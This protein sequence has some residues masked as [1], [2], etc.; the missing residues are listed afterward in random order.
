[1]AKNK[2]DRIAELND[3]IAQ[4][5]KRQTV[6]R[7]QHNKQE[8]KARN[9]RLCQRGGQVEKLLP[10]L[11]TLTDE[12]FN[13]FVEK[14]LLTPFSK[15]VLAELTSPPKPA[16]PEQG[17]GAGATHGGGNATAIPTESA[18]KPAAA[19]PPKTNVTVLDAAANASGEAGDTARRAS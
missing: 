9:H 18:G 2:L 10:G 11:I 7:Q 19:P 8:R 3:E 6:L 14:T 15:R 17:G 13:V 4:I 5:K 12:Q 1:M 16:A